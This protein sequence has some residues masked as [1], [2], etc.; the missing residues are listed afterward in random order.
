MAKKINPINATYQENPYIK[1]LF[2]EGQNL[3]QG[4]MTGANQ[5]EQNILANQANV[6]SNVNR[7]ATSGSQALA[8]AAGVQ[9]QTNQSFNDLA[10]AEAQN[11]QNRFGIQSQVSQLMAQEGD[12]VYQDK[13]R[14]YYDDLNYKRGLE[15]A[16]MQN[17]ANFWGGLDNAIGAGISLFTPGGLLAGKKTDP[18]SG[19]ATD[20]NTGGQRSAGGFS[21]Q[22]G[23]P[24]NFPMYRR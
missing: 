16:A 5:A 17:K 10:M 4:R 24:N 13:L 7:N 1:N 8:T 22:Y 2:T 11:K 3:Y 20:I 14:N 9:G 15:G 21:G 19:V 12:K 6:L 23:P 18:N